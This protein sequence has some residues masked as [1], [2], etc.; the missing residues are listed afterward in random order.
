MAMPKED[1]LINLMRSW[2]EG[3]I[4]TSEWLIHEKGYSKGLLQQYHRSGWIELIGKGAYRRAQLD[5]SGLPLRNPT[6]LK[7]QGGV[8]A[9]Q[10][11][12]LDHKKNAP[13]PVLVA[14]R[15]ALELG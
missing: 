5:Q 12:P 10:A 2:P 3:A 7:W 13:P 8:W 9:L 6:P 1:K 14:A 11:L 4:F 15:T